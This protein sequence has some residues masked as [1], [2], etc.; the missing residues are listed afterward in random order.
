LTRKCV[1]SVLVFFVAVQA[2][3]Q[4]VGNTSYAT[5][6]FV[7]QVY[8]PC[9]QCTVGLDPTQLFFAANPNSP[10]LNAK[11]MAQVRALSAQQTTAG[12]VPTAGLQRWEDTYEASFPAGTFPDEPAWIQADRNA[13]KFP[14]LPEFVA[15]RNF[16][17]SHSQYLDVAFDGGTMPPQPNYFRSWG[18]QWGHISPLTPLDEAD[19]PPSKPTSCNWGDD[20]AYRWAQ[21]TRVTGGYGLQLS[22]FT[23]GQPYQSTL[24]D[25]NPRIVAAFS[26]A[27][28]AAGVPAGSAALQSAW[29]NHHAFNEWTDFLDQGYAAFYAAMASQ[30]GAAAGHA[31]LV[32]GQCSLSPAFKRTEGVDERILAEKLSPDNFMCI[33]DDQVIQVGRSG[34]LA[35]P[36]MAELAGY[37]LAAAREPLMRNG[38][39]LEADDAAYWAA[40][41]SFYPGL[42][43]AT[44]QELG[45][46]LLK[47]LWVW[48]AWAH[49]ADRAGQ[50]RRAIAFASRDYW[51]AG[52]LGP[53][54]TVQS[55]IASILPARPFGAALYYP[56]SVER[57]IE[58]ANTASLPAGDVPNTYLPPA[59]LQG[60]L[61]S[62]APVGYYVSDAALPFISQAAGNAPSAWVLLDAGNFLPADERAALEAVAP[63]V[64]TLAQLAAL[65]NQPLII[66]QGL[67]GFGFRDR[68]GQLVVV[69]SNP[70][71]AANA[72]SV[73]GTIEARLGAGIY[74]VTE[75]QSGSKQ[76][77]TA[78][79]GVVRWETS[80]TRWD[81]EIF[82]VTK[83][84]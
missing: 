81:T 22:D 17:S 5:L 29:I 7:S 8:R 44:Q 62:G 32:I 34:P 42:P 77:L 72:G 9:W 70:S 67:A 55:L 50:V 11:L 71:T 33:W 83:S 27:F 21:T 6:P 79:D 46:K 78:T 10:F 24:H 41:K 76:T 68:R 4:Q 47:R 38:A 31:A 52:T 73:G 2:R 65:P 57:A 16:I 25:V 45:V 58:A 3:A 84:Q 61:D 12:I 64:T 20:F 30:A 39:N 15:W 82:E 51:D 37:V 43:A 14:T 48:S 19:C 18:G 60:L 53:L 66:P 75:L 35:S 23:D 49:I 80:L 63:V 26:K 56:V 54:G 59:E 69:A 36:P 74:T 28:P 13:G 40:I 1:F